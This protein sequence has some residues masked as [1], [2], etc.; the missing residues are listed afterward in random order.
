[1]YR[2]T[3]LMNAAVSIAARALPSFHRQGDPEFGPGPAYRPWR[4]WGDATHEGA[5][6]LVHAAVLSSNAFNTQPWLFHLGQG[7]VDVHAD[8]ARNLG[9]FDPYLREMFF[10][11]GCAIENLAVTAPAIGFRA[12]WT[13]AHDALQASPR[14]PRPMLAA[15]VHLVP[16]ARTTS[17]L[18]D[19]LP[20]RHT[21]RDA[22][23]ATRAV[24]ASML[25]ALAA[26]SAAG[27]S[28]RVFLYTNEDARRAL[29]NLFWD[30]S[31]R[32]AAAP[33]VSRGAAPWYRTTEDAWRRRRDGV[34]L[35]P[36]LTSERGRTPPPYLELMQSGRLFGIIA[37]RDRYDA[38][39]TVHAG[40]VWQRLHLTATALGLAA[41][42][43]NGAVELIDHERRL[44]LPPRATAA[45]SAITRRPAWQPTFMFYMGYP[46][47]EAVASP[48][49][50]VR[51]VII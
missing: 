7:Y 46:T 24:P 1:M 8:T 44:G 20:H 47:T 19:A 42:P 15:R 36:S 49:R 9:G 18:F 28:T 41:R 12:S 4:T 11:L 17:E 32:F 35:D 22:F 43:A 25:N 39:Q 16:Q 14:P 37:V 27:P 33:D 13:P 2:R 3:F 23:D 10:S 29:A 6:G 34:Y 38:A 51:D 5:L 26:A 21:N 45:I 31:V 50:A 40:T 30:A 48:R